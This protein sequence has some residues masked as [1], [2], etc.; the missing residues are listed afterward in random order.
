M[1]IKQH[2]VALGVAASILV[3]GQTSPAFAEDITINLWTRADRSGPL[4]AGNI[5]SAAETVNKMLA[6]A[7][8]DDTVSVEIHENN[9]KGFDA[10]ALN[11]MKAF[12]A[13]KAPDVYVAAHEWISAFAEAGY[14]MNLEDHIAANPE[15]YEDMIPVLWNSTLYKGARYAI[16]Q[17][18]EIRM[19]FYRKDMLRSIG[20]S[21]DFI[22]S[23]PA[24]VES[25]AFTIWDLSELAKEVVDAGK[26]EYGIIHRPNVGPDFLMQWP[27]SALTRWMRKAASCR[28]RLRHWKGS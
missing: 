22:E 11:L 4:R 3:S 24:M 18:S 10:D 14:A 8:S 23:L 12:A 21:D 9:A 28:P 7:G 27:A 25:G 19:F 17:D 1:P 6:A 16:P 15:Y 13:N 20:K 2:L 5:V 26:A